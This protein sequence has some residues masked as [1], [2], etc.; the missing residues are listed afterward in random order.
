MLKNEHLL[1][2]IGADPAENEPLARAPVEGRLP[3][4]AAR[5]P[6]RGA[7]ARAPLVL[8]LGL[9]CRG[10]PQSALQPAAAARVDVAYSV[11]SL[12]I[13]HLRCFWRMIYTNCK[14]VRMYSSVHKEH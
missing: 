12:C 6:P 13:L 8:A 14:A 7:R 1:A 11:F 5:V 4:G 9:E 10:D 2:K 3:P